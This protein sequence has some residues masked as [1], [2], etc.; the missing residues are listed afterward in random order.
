MP[1]YN[2]SR[3]SSTRL[4]HSHRT[5]SGGNSKVGLNNLALTQKDPAQ[6]AKQQNIKR[7]GHSA[8][9]VRIHTQR[10]LYLASITHLVNASD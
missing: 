3:G 6:P 9:E 10:D 5:S 7:A 1:V 4:Q 2:R 8:T